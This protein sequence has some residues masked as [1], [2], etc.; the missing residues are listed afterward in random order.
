[1][2]KGVGM[3]WLAEGDEDVWPVVLGRLVRWVGGLFLGLREVTEG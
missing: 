2:R 3:R 1:M